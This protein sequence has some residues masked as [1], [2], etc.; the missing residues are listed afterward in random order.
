MQPEKDSFILIVCAKKV[1]QLRIYCVTLVSFIQ[2][3][4]C[5]YISILVPTWTKASVP[6]LDCVFVSCGSSASRMCRIFELLL[7]WSRECVRSSGMFHETWSPICKLLSEKTLHYVRGTIG[8]F[9]LKCW[10]RSWENLRFIEYNWGFLL[11]NKIMK[12]IRRHTTRDQ[13]MGQTLF[14]IFNEM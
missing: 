2:P 4:Y 10:R 9:G 12:T 1:W 7:N 14:T 3:L 5:M 11:S 8:G 6:R 13:F